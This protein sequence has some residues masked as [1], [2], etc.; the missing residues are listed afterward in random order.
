MKNICLMIV[1]AVVAACSSPL[2]APALT[3]IPSTT[4]S[5]TGV[6]PSPTAI[7]PTQA[8]LPNPQEA[9]VIAQ[10]RVDEPSA[11][12]FGFDSV[13]VPSHLDPSN[14]TRID[15]VSNEIIAV[16]EGTGFHPHDVLIA[17]DSVW[18]S[19]IRNDMSQIDPNTNLII[20]KI[21]SHRYMA[22]GFDSIWA[23]TDTNR[24][25]RIDPATHE[26]IA[27]IQY[28]NASDAPDP[29]TNEC[30]H[31][32]LITAAAVWVDR[33]DEGELFKIDPTTNSI[34]QTTSYIDPHLID[35][36]NV[37]TTVPPGI[38]TDFVW[39]LVPSGLIRIDPNTGAGLTFLSMARVQMSGF[40]VV[41][42]QVVWVSGYG[43]IERVNVATNQIDAIYK[44]VPGAAGKLGIGFGSVWLIYE[45][46]N[47]VQR[48]DIAP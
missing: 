38:G 10:W 17:G 19:G 37:Q 23:L 20:A 28:A 15:P 43:Q 13:W 6:P 26:T 16:I 24:L 40:L 46:G 45:S 34:T 29:L 12:A 3:A 48:L 7:P 30:S 14:L 44:T 1:C 32:V 4:I 39:V 35:Q 22:Y 25:D 2:S 31:D 36:A 33:C 18:V 9:T 21:L 5:S 27:V 11:I 41:T 8:L 42:E 47:L